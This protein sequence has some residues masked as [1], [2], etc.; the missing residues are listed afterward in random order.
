MIKD[1]IIFF[2]NSTE[3]HWGKTADE[4]SLIHP[5]PIPYHIKI[6]NPAKPMLTNYTGQWQNRTQN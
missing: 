3:Q 2:L 5:K 4:T 1:N 6:Q